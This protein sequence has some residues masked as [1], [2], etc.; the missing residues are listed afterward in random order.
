M[1]Y[2][3][4]GKKMM[5]CKIYITNLHFKSIIFLVPNSSA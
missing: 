4:I 2:I 5:Y 3:R 1:D